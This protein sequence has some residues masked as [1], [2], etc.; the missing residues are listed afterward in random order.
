MKIKRLDT[1]VKVNGHD[2]VL[3]LRTK[4][5][6]CYR[7]FTKEGNLVAFE[8]F[9]VKIRKEETIGGV[10]Y[11]TR[12]TYPSTTDF[13]NT[14]WSLMKSTSARTIQERLNKLQQ[15]YDEELRTIKG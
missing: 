14:A 5:F 15:E 9:R 11:P 4:N 1:E 12:E 6:A 7:Q 3:H 10:T 13:G 8:L 2:Y